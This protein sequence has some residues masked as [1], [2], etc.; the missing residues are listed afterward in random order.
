V[1]IEALEVPHRPIAL[2]IGWQGIYCFRFDSAWLKVGKAG[3]KS[4]PR[5][6]SQ[7]YKPTR[8]LSTLACSLIRYAHVTTSEDPRTPNLKASLQRVSPDEIAEW[9]KANTER[10]NLLIR[11]EMGAGSL[12]RLEAI[13]HRI[14]DPVFE[15]RWKF[16]GPAA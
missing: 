16:G 2:P 11:A 10:V 3:P 9:I 8:A 1:K 13:G 14:L 4:G 6:V 7:H 15:G 5:W 12:A